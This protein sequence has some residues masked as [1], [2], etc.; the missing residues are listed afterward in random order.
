MLW[1]E[2]LWTMASMLGVLTK[3]SKKAVMRRIMLLKNIVVE[4]KQTS[5]IYFDVN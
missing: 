1:F 5:N 2:F 4:H 3:R